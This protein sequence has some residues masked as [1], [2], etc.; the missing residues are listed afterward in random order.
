[1]ISRWLRRNFAGLFA[2][3]L[4][5]VAKAGITP[6]MLSAGGLLLMI[7]AGILI[8]A[9]LLMLAG[10]A[11]LFA[12]L[13]DAADGELARVLENESPR[14]EFTDSICDHLGD[15]AVYLGICFFLV[16]HAHAKFGL[17]VLI[18]MF[19]SLF[20]SLVRSRSQLIGADIGG[21][22]VATRCERILV[23]T[24]GLIGNAIVTALW[25]LAALNSVSAAQRVLYALR[26]VRGNKGEELHDASERQRVSS[27]QIEAGVSLK[28]RL[29]F[30]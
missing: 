28:R 6:T 11:V 19:G 20:G 9:D 10:F 13:M 8:V 27:P 18:A 3:Q 14:G 7:C 23:L 2:Q 30:G 16:H 12:G 5:S 1:M 21:V 22:G 17:L 26:I 4:S 25:R 15:F 24:A 29:H